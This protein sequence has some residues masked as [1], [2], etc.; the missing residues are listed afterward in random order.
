MKKI[1]MNPNT[2]FA[3]R[4]KFEEGSGIL[5]VPDLEAS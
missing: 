2:F 5:K 3:C 1:I 4:L